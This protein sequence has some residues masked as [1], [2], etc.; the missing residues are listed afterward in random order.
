MDLFASSAKGAGFL[1]SWQHE[2]QKLGYNIRMKNN[3]SGREI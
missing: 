2:A 3:R 1:L